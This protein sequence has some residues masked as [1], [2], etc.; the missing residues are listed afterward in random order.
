MAA[1][2]AAEEAAVLA[3]AKALKGA[4]RRRLA[5][6]DS[7]EDTDARVLPSLNAVER[8]FASKKYTRATFDAVKAQV[9]LLL[10]G[11]AGTARLSTTGPRG[12]TNRA[13][14]TSTTGK[15]PQ[16]VRA[17]VGANKPSGAA[18]RAKDLAQVAAARAKA[19]TKPRQTLPN[20]GSVKHGDGAAPPA[21]GR[22]YVPPPHLLR[23]HQDRLA[24]S[25]QRRSFAPEDARE[26]PTHLI[27]VVARAQ[28]TGWGQVSRQ[29]QLA[30]EAAERARKQAK[31]ERQR[32]QKLLLDRQMEEQS[33]EARREAERQRAEAAELE[34]KLQAVREAEEGEYR[35][36]LAKMERTRGL[37]EEQLQERRRIEAEANEREMFDGWLEHQEA[38]RQ[39]A[40]DAEAKRL[41]KVAAQA[42]ME[43]TLAENAVR[44]EAR[45]KEEARAREED[46]RLNKEHAKVLAEREAR[47]RAEVEARKKKVEDALARGGAQQ[48]A[49]SMEERAR[50]DAERAAAEQ[51]AYQRRQDVDRAKRRRDEL[52]RTAEQ[53]NALDRMMDLQQRERERERRE[54]AE[55]GA[56]ERREAAERRRREKD[57]RRERRQA[58]AADIERQ[59][60]AMR[61]EAMRRFVDASDMMTPLE[62]KIHKK[63]ITGQSRALF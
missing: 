23:E 57:A 9:Q 1:A 16:A 25:Q 30:A 48:L 35:Q 58:Q 62:M 20:Y 21:K 34:R 36:K 17:F 14:M 52:R 3:E 53:L 51:A 61:E 46:A 22:A 4:L 39:I 8:F 40:E 63:V 45:R 59:K 12:T 47:Q 19:L 7:T 10:S 18:D 49:A 60:A 41:R 11:K 24:R 6:L 44:L 28:T 2:G 26:M 54:K 13:P 5:A 31:L 43:Q 50:E 42:E 15:R 27:E 29:E 38:L 37:F 32:Q 56:K 55:L 33:E